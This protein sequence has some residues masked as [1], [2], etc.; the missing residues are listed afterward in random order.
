MLNGDGNE[1]GF[2]INRSYQQKH[3]FARAALF[4]SF[5]AVVLQDYNDVLCDQIVTF[6]SF[7]LFLWRNCRTCLPKIFFPVFMFAFIF[8]TAAYFHLAGRQHFSFSHGTAAMKFSCFSSKEI[9]LLCFESPTLALSLLSNPRE[10]I[11]KIT[12]KKIRL[13]CCFFLPKSPGGHTISRKK[14][15]DLPVVS[16]LSTELFYIGMPV[17]R[18][19]GRAYG[20]VIANISRMGRLLNFLTQGASTTSNYLSSNYQ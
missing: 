11:S 13:C 9:R 20:H 1:N 3:K 2:K 4:L 8:F 16:Y 6:G 10:C 17:V 18:T 15:V 5:F 14:H 19:D 7:T 12:S